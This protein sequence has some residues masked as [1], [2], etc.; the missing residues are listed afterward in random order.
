MKKIFVFS[1]L[2]VI[3]FICTSCSIMPKTPTKG[4]WYCEEISVSIEFYIDPL[5][6]SVHPRIRST[7]MYD[8]EGNY[9]ELEKN[10]HYSGQLDFYYED[11]DGNE[12]GVYSGF[13]K[14]RNDK[15]IMYLISKGD[16]TDNYKTQIELDYE[17]CVF[18]EIES[19]EKIDEL[20]KH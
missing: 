12:V 14:Y 3:I 18:I 19:Y 1:T 8:D 5:Y 15:F 10:W 20:I 6:S 13:Y 7:R 11:A 4:I 2:F 16:P 17:K 9:Q